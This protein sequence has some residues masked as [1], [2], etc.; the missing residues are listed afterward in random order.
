MVQR[1]I[2]LQNLLR[3]IK[4]GVC[5]AESGSVFLCLVWFGLA[6]WPV[7]RPTPGPERG[8]HPSLGSA[9]EA[10]TDSV[11]A[12]NKTAH[13]CLFSPHHIFYHN[14]EFGIKFQKLKHLQ[15]ILWKPFCYWTFAIC[16][17]IVP[18]TSSS[19]ARSTSRLLWIELWNLLW[20]RICWLMVSASSPKGEVSMSLYNTHKHNH[21]TLLLI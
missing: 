19:R 11:T 20:F 14:N 4:D 13:S 8:V 9:S 12:R 17:L 1:H 18:H 21:F 10:Q 2:S 6:S 15:F 16:S 3:I 5:K 7:T